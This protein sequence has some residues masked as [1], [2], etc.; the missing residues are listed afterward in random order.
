[1]STASASTSTV[2]RKGIFRDTEVTVSSRSVTTKLPLTCLPAGTFA[3]VCSPRARASASTWL[4]VPSGHEPS[5]TE[6]V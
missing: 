6:S 2:Q 3:V 5:V 4:T 1:V